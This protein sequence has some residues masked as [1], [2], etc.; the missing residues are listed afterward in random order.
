MS[1]SKAKGRKNLSTSGYYRLFA[2]DDED[3]TAISLAELCTKIHAC[4]ISKGNELDGYYLTNEEFNPNNVIIKMS[5]SSGLLSN[6]HYS[7]FVVEK[8]DFLGIPKGQKSIE[9]DYL[10]ISEDAIEIYEI[11]DGDNFDTKK[12]QGE[13]DSLT[14]AKQYFE[15]I[16]PE[17][18][19]SYKIVFW[20][21]QDV[22]SISFKVNNLSPET[23]ITG[24]MFCEKIGCNFTKINQHRKQHSKD[25]K[26]WFFEQI[27]TIL[28]A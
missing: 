18:H 13:I 12:S 5:S 27:H 15:E 3:E 16:F 10:V 17:K 28:T 1:L 20:N 4:V 25:N 19:V 7:K 6:G 24:E 21:A 22:K 11:K 14:A 26:E 2:E 8:G 23:L 9:I